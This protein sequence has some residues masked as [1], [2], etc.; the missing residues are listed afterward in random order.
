MTLIYA[1]GGGYGHLTRTAALVRTL[2]IKDY[3]VLTACK[4]LARRI[5]PKENYH[6]LDNR[7]SQE[8]REYRVH[9][10]SIIDDYKPST[11]IL[12]SFPLGILGEFADFSWPKDVE[13]IYIAR[14]LKWQ[15]YMAGKGELPKF[16]KVYQVENLIP[17]H[18]EFLKAN[19]SI[20]NLV[21]KYF[22]P[23]A[24]LLDSEP[25][26]IICHSGN[27]REI[28]MLCEKALK[29][30]NNE[31][32]YLISPNR[33]E[34][35]PEGIIYKFHHPANIYFEKASFV[36]SAAGFNIMQEMKGLCTKHFPFPVERRFDD[37][38][39]RAS[40]LKVAN[41]VS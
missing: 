3:L 17:D 19:F 22:R 2:G 26:G 25:Y 27:D 41:Q 39:L 5:F 38:A 32:L 4:E 13:L 28:Q 31:K 34:I 1:I 8:P 7:L 23:E 24:E 9:L 15:K 10:N 37:Q 20:E 12:D 29:I 40:L 33:P 14:L 30:R 21:L 16:K 6:I 35:L 18:E 11:F 36:V